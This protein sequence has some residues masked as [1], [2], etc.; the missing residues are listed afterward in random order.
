MMAKAMKILFL[1]MGGFLLLCAAG[2]FIAPLLNHKGSDP[3]FPSAPPDYPLYDEAAINNEKDWHINNTHDPSIFKDEASGQYYVYSTDFKTGGTPRPAIMVRKSP[4]LIHWDWV[5]YAFDSVPSDAAVW[6]EAKGLWAPEIAKFNNTY[7]LYYAA[8]R[9]GTNQSFIGVATSSSPEGPW[10]DQGEVIKTARGNAPNA[11]DPNIVRD[12][13]EEAWLAY[14]SFFG[15]IYISRLDAATGKLK[16]F[17]FGEIIATRDHATTSGAVEGPYIKYNSDTKKY[18]L[19]V[20]YDSL[21]ETY[22]VRVGR[23][24]TITGPYL[25]YNGH[26]LTDTTGAP[27]SEVGTKILNGYQFDLNAGWTSPGHNS[28]LQDGD[29]WY[30]IHHARGGSNKHWSYLHIRKIIWTKDGWP[31]VSPERYAGETLQEI[32]RKMIAGDWERISL[33]PEINDQLPSY[34]L[35]LEADGKMKAPHGQGKWKLTVPNTLMLHWTKDADDKEI[36]LLETVTVL[37]SWDWERSKPTLV[38]TGLSSKG[39]AVWGKKNPE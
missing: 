26:E 19:F 1:C 35:K 37:P 23:A 21:V 15:G 34:A 31:V 8:S 10:M 28:V 11:I 24:D 9:F 3:K 27:P 30:M 7:Y 29:N 4:D 25:D 5:G 22:N 2:F 32:P 18:Y 14:G 13:N 16:E 6:T 39:I 12:D 36:N 38:F 17:D 33:L 20:S